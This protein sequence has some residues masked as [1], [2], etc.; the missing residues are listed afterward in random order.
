M[1]KLTAFLL[2]FCLLTSSS[3][4]SV[5]AATNNSVV[6]V[7]QQNEKGI[8]QAKYT[9]VEEDKTIVVVISDGIKVTNVDSH[10]GYY[11]IY[12]TDPKPEYFIDE[13]FDLNTITIDELTSY[14]NDQYLCKVSNGAGCNQLDATMRRPIIS[15]Y[16]ATFVDSSYYRYSGNYFSVKHKGVT[17]SFQT[18]DSNR[19]NLAINFKKQ[20]MDIDSYTTDTMMG[21]FG[22]I[23]YVGTAIEYIE[24]AYSI[25]QKGLSPETAIKTID[26]ICATIPVLSTVYNTAFTITNGAVAQAARLTANNIFVQLQKF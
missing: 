23:P 26:A 19:L 8:T 13:D 7:I 17:H 18:N 11:E 25:E 6:S 10:Q 16:S 20:L 5:F 12:M 15:S 9:I 2:S 14:A 1:K 3:A 4:F 22:Y 24:L 21:A